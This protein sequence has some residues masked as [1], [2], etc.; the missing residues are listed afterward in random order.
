MKFIREFILFCALLIKFIISI[1]IISKKNSDVDIIFK[2]SLVKIESKLI[3]PL[4]LN[5]NIIS[6]SVG[7]FI[8][9]NLIVAN[10]RSV[11]KSSKINII[12]HDGTVYE[13]GVFY[14]DAF[15]PIT[16]LKL[17]NVDETE[18][19]SKIS[20]FPLTFENKN[21]TLN[22]EVTLLSLDENNF[23]WRNIGNV[24][25]LNDTTTI[26]YTDI[27]GIDY[28]TKN[29]NKFIGAPI[30]NKKNKSNYFITC[31]NRNS[32]I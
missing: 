27:I 4:F 8:E 24:V 19:N 26:R 13:A 12:L 25:S 5:E 10:K 15:L 29:M 31:S 17:K 2:H 21:I 16:L 1:Q 22:E 30:I 32:F 7:F 6:K 9:A 3:F 11:T 20:I 14:E 28:P 18:I 23:L